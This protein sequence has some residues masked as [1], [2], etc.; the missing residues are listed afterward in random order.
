M[1]YSM[2]NAREK[3]SLN[4]VRQEE[5][6]LLLELDELCKSNGLRYS[7]AGGSLLGAVRH[8]GFIPWDDDIDI[9]MPRP[10]YEKAISLFRADYLGADRSLEPIS[11]DWSCPVFFKYVNRKIKV[12]EHYSSGD[13]AYLWIDVF[14][15]DGL[16][17]DDGELRE[18]YRQADSLRR[19]FALCRAD[20][21]EG[22]TPA[23][24]AAKRVLVPV[25]RCLG[26]GNRVA[27]KLD[28]LSRSTQF[29]STGYA[30]ILSWG[31]YGSGE[32]YE[33]T[34]FDCPVEV[35]FEGHMF[36]AMSCWDEYL[37]GIYGD[38]MK[39]PPVEK[40]ETHELDAW[41]VAQ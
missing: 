33:D 1:S 17:S 3:L 41:V 11:G 4:D 9:V 25:L 31:L 40:R 32:R 24:R 14:P 30:G 2:A 18:K 22:K 26:V 21:R 39:L 15:S 12:K 37:R 36:P 20:S 13:G 35:M 38:Y 10:D 34:A 5:F 29:G 16:P 7:L 28:T 23:K 27:K 8:K 19:L 6:R